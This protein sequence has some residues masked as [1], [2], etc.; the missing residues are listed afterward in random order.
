MVVVEEKIIVTYFSSGLGMVSLEG[1]CGKTKFMTSHWPCL[2]LNTVPAIARETNCDLK[3]K[4]QTIVEKTWL[5]QSYVHCIM[6]MH[7][8]VKSVVIGLRQ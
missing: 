8:V 7:G 6:E 2:G 1:Y 3:Q 4:Q 5:I